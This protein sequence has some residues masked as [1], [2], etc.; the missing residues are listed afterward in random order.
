MVLGH[1][2]AVLSLFSA[3]GVAKTPLAP[4]GA[5]WRPPGPP[6][7]PMTPGMS[8][9]VIVSHSGSLWV[10]FD[11]SGVNNSSGYTTVPPYPPHPKLNSSL[12]KWQKSIFL[13][14]FV[15][16]TIQHPIWDYWDRKKL[17]N[18]MFWGNWVCAIKCTIDC[19][20]KHMV[21][22]VEAFFGFHQSALG[23]KM[24]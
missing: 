21:Y 7:A 14:F 8:S 10:I 1:Y 11:P 6:G 5:P 13:K 16:S 24:C 12:K 18:K 17:S 9:W 2:F 19:A 4:P 22:S 15:W 20:P 3:P 23:I